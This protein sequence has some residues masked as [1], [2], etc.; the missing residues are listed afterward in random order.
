MVFGKWGGRPHWEFDAL[1]LGEDRHGTW[2]GVPPGTLMTRPGAEFRNGVAQV[3]LVPD[4]AY[5]ASFYAPGDGGDVGPNPCEVYVD[6]STVPTR[7]SGRVHMVDLDLDV[8][9]GW[10]GR[11][12]VDDEDEFAD[13]R[14]RFG[15]PDQVV[16]LASES[17]TDVHRAVAG[18]EEPFDGP[19][20][21]RWF[22]ALDALVAARYTAVS[23]AGAGPAGTA[24]EVAGR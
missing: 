4:A 23:A 17:C 7:E 6:I 9:R 22:A 12:W 8:V 13:H 15:Y 2:L 11:V 24:G 14:I 19:T 18:R 10:T 16:A 3:V 20:A 1:L 5:V 21:R